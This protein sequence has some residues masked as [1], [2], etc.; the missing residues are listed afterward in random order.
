M[1]YFLFRPNYNIGVLGTSMLYN[2]GNSILAFTPQVCSVDHFHVDARNDRRRLVSFPFLFVFGYSSFYK[3]GS[4]RSWKTWKVKV[5]NDFIF[6][7][8]KVMEFN[9]RS[10][11]VKEN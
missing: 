9:C 6:Q 5:F 4:Y 2:V 10:L 3:Q 11:K 8:W 1:A 7:A